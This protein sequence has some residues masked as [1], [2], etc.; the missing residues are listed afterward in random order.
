FTGLEIGLLLHETLFF[1]SLMLGRETFLDL[2]FDFRFLL[3]LGLLLLAGNK[4]R[5][6]RDERQNAKLFHCEVR[7]GWFFVIRRKLRIGCL[8]DRQTNQRPGDAAAGVAVETGTTI[9]CSIL[10]RRTFWTF[11]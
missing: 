10:S 9:T 5:E 3:F 4:K 1:V 2:P 8:R 11:A 6:S 7:P